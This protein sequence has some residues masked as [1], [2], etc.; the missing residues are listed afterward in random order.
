MAELI[1]V[2]VHSKRG[3][4]PFDNTWCFLVGSGEV[5]PTSEANILAT[6]FGNPAVTDFD[7]YDSAAPLY[8][9]EPTPLQ[10]IIAFMQALRFPSVT[11]TGATISD[12]VKGTDKM[13]PV[14]ISQVGTRA[15]PVGSP[16]QVAPGNIIWQINKQPNGLGS[17]FGQLELRGALAD[18]EV[19]FDGNDLLDWTSVDAL[20]DARERME[21]AYENAHLDLYFAG[22]TGGSTGFTLAIPHAFDDESLNPGSWY[23][24]T[25]IRTLLS[26]GPKGRQVH[27]GRKKKVVTPP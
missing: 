2:V 8:P 6:V 17:D 15:F 27:R 24:A 16:D 5:S 26:A 4:K 10:A 11:I 23:G 22:A 20:N 19:I 13:Y 7:V 21:T 14:Y 18:G 9:A 1:K 12:G 25:P 3:T